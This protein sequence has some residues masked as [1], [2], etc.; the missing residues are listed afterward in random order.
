MRI[1]KLTVALA[2]QHLNH[3]VFGHT[4][5]LHGHLPLINDRFQSNPHLPWQLSCAELY[6]S[7][8]TQ[9]AVW[10]L[11]PRTPFVTTSG[12]DDIIDDVI[13][14]YTYWKMLTPEV[15]ALYIDHLQQVLAAA[16][17]KEGGLQATKQQFK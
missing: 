9:T 8:P 16:V 7:Y 1:D 4:G 15:C 3:Q 17:Q 5:L 13:M 2:A 14:Q 12:F 6:F 11:R 10:H